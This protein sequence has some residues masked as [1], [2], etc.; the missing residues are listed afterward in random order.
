LSICKI[1][2]F[3]E[4]NLFS[5]DSLTDNHYSKILKKI[6]RKQLEDSGN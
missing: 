2:M 5:Y 3:K 4:G 6:V 1:D